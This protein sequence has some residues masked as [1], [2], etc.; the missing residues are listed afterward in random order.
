MTRRAYPIGS[1]EPRRLLLEACAAD[2]RIISTLSPGSRATIRKE[3]GIAP[4]EPTAGPIAGASAGPTVINRHHYKG[5]SLPHPWLYIGRNDRDPSKASP[6]RNPFGVK[7][8]GARALELYRE[9]LRRCIDDREPD[10]MAE[11]AKITAGHHLVCSCAPRPCHGD[12]VVE[13]WRELHAGER[14]R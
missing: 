2:H 4:P 14:S 1:P 11:L 8:Y 12:V 3:L 5:K 6:L 9:H 10:V 13:V 7:R